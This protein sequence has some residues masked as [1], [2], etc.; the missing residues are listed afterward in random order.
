MTTQKVSTRVL[1]WVAV[2]VAVGVVAYLIGIGHGGSST[3]TVIG[4]GTADASS[5]GGGTA[6][7]GAGETLNRTWGFA[8]SIPSD[9]EWS[10]SSGEVHEGSRPPCLPPAKAVSVKNMEALQF[11]IP[12]GLGTGI[13]LWVQC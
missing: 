1:A 10:D 6:Y 12:S 5:G 7:V 4:P 9:V 3:I 2:T 8:Y 11:T 13:V